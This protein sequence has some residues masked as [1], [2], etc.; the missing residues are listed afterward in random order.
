MRKSVSYGETRSKKSRNLRHIPLMDISNTHFGPD[1]EAAKKSP[2]APIRQRNA[3]WWRY[4]QL[5]AKDGHVTSNG[6]ISNT[7]LS[8]ID[9]YLCSTYLHA[10]REVSQSNPNFNEEF[11]VYGAK[12]MVYRHWVPLAAQYELNG[13]EI[14]DLDAGLVEQLSQTD[15]GDATLETWHPP[16]DAFFI[17]FGKQDNIKIPFDE[18][19]EYLDGAFVAVTPYSENERRIKFGFTTSKADGSAV[20]LP[21]YFID[22]NPTEQL[23][24]VSQAIEHALARKQ[25]EFPIDDSVEKGIRGINSFRRAEVEDA[26]DL[27]RQGAQL[28]VNALFYL[29]SVNS[30]AEGRGPGRDVP[31]DA[32]ARWLQSSAQARRKHGSRLTADGYGLVRMVGHEFSAG[33]ATGGN[34][35]S[36]HWRRGHWRMQP[37]GP[38]K[39]MMRRIWI[40][41]VKVAAGAGEASTP[42][43]HIYVVPPVT[44][45]H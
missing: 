12:V 27:L 30:S 22:L 24:P 4:A 3:L 43:G 29:Q 23:L 33:R 36:A 16:Y 41:P 14:F 21:G 1:T 32:H 8:M 26:A 17:R 5:A 2:Y 44:A 35:I 19:F 10:F 28:L 7:L 25:A 20:M 40:K 39:S 9:E 38:G 45:P 37:H 13:R 11:H 6:M 18:D 15:L 31:P 42:P 34:T